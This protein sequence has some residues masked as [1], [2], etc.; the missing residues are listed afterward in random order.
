[1]RPKTLLASGAVVLAAL[2]FAPEAR[3]DA[4]A[5]MFLGGGTTAWKQARL[6][7]LPE[8]ALAFDIGIGTTPNAPLI[9]GGLF[10]L[11]PIFN[12]TGGGADLSLMLRVAT[13]GFQAGNFGIAVDVGM[14]ERP[15]WTTSTGLTGEVTL[16]APFGLQISAGGQY[17]TDN[18][19][20]ITV[21]A[22]IDLLRLTIYRQVGLSNWSNP[23]PA[24]T[25]QSKFGIFN[26]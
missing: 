21:V 18:A 24:Y 4:S 20:G 11:Q 14:Y 8:A 26:F 1:V 23:S 10:R 25:K 3:A 9:V 5:W 17:G 13:H 2:A 7:L 6:K 12:D 16:G 15:W 22:G 19:Q